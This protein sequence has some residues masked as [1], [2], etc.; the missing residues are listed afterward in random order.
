MTYK[1]KKVFVYDM[2][3]KLV[4]EFDM[5]KEMHEGWGLVHREMT[6]KDG[7]K[8]MRFYA[9]DG[10]DKVFII[11]PNNWEVEDSYH[12]VDD[13]GKAISDLNDMEIID[14]KLFIIVYLTSK[15][16]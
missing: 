14:H 16:I 2:H 1:E 3:L 9:S 15:V 4:K 13:D 10:T 7:K 5:P 11:N 12:V 6:L 8:G